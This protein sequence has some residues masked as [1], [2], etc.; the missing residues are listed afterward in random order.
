[1]MALFKYIIDFFLSLRTTLWLLGMSLILMFAGALIMPG[2]KEF[3]ALHSVPL[4]D[5]MQSQPLKLTW[6]LW[7]LIVILA[8]LTIN[9]LF[10]S[11]ESIVKKRGVTQWL[12]LI[13]PQIIHIG[14]LFVLFAHLL[15]A[16]GA[17]QEAALVREGSVLKIRGSDRVLK[18]EDI[19]ISLNYY[20]HITDW[21]VKVDYQSEGR[22]LYKD[23][24]R[25]NNPSTY[26]SLNVN[27]RDIK[28]YPQA[29]LLQINREPGALWALSGGILFIIG[30]VTL[31]LLKIRMER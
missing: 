12:L 3:Q 2:R 27:V 31:V 24:I 23:I 14:F 9:T 4:L 7:T 16:Y 10:C 18:V 21:Q 29:V 1:M 5:W 17:S 20:G 22:S 28:P 13:S 25:P 26:M 6:W 15:S 19:N 30:T 8:L 11:V